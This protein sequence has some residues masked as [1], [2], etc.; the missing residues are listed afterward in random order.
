MGSL[1]NCSLKNPGLKG[2]LRNQKWYFK[3]PT[4]QG[5]LKKCLKY[6]SL[7]N[8]GLKGSLWNQKWCHKEPCFEGSLRHHY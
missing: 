4:F 2:S 8:P 7:K 6:G 5:S 3:D 1:K